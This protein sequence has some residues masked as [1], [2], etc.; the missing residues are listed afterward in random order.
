MLFWQRLSLVLLA[1]TMS[2]M[3]FGQLLGHSYFSICITHNNVL[4]R[5]TMFSLNERRLLQQTHYSHQRC[6]TAWDGNL[7][8]NISQ[9]QIHCRCWQRSLMF[10]QVHPI[11]AFMSYTS[12]INKQTDLTTIFHV[13]LSQPL[14]QAWSS[15]SIHS[16]SCMFM[17][18]S[19]CK[20]I[21]LCSNL[22]ASFILPAKSHFQ[23]SHVTCRMLFI[24]QKLVKIA[25]TPVIVQTIVTSKMHQ[26][27]VAVSFTQLSCL[28]AYVLIEDV[29]SSADL[30]GSTHDKNNIPEQGSY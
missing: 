26:Q 15:F 30:R 19:Q 8:V 24:W 28:L 22:T 5:Q 1:P 16:A 23:I 3:K 4:N 25:R 6:T 7:T 12:L 13:N 10:Y 17:H 21:W 11:V 18:F 20:P 14:A 27:R 9:P 2:P 29:L